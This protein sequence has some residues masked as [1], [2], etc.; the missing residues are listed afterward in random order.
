M[1]IALTTVGTWML[2]GAAVFAQAHIPTRYSGAFPSDGV[3][4]N[5]TGTFTGKALTLRWRVQAASSPRTGSFTCTAT[6]P[7]QTRCTGSYRSEDG[8]ASGPFRVV[9]TWSGGTPVATAFSH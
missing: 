6:S 5:I 9:V 1:R 4:M 2:L 3:R 8:K 7:T